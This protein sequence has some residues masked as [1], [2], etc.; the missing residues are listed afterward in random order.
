MQKNTLIFHTMLLS[1][2][3]LST[4]SVEAKEPNPKVFGK[5]YSAVGDVVNGQSQV[6]YYRAHSPHLNPNAAH[7]FLDHKL[8][9]VLLPGGYTLFCISPGKHLLE[10][11]FE[12]Q[13]GTNKPVAFTTQL[14]GGKTYFLK[15]DEDEN[16]PPLAITPFQA[17]QE[18]ALTHQQVHALTRANQL[19]ACQYL[20][21]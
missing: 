14:E 6:I 11:K 20:P 17:A 4:A 1:M 10:K 16:R 12:T 15:V 5:S 21:K 18:L 7:I 3:I 9:S 13:R 19:V 2:S 8:Q